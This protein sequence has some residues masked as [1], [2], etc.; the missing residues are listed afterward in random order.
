MEWTLPEGYV[1]YA[2]CIPMRREAA[3]DPD[4]KE[5]NDLCVTRYYGQKDKEARERHEE[6]LESREVPS[7]RR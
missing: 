6:S 1:L 5:T 4:L 2:W 7:P 3:E